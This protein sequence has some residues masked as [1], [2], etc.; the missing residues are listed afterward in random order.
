MFNVPSEEELQDTDTLHRAIYHKMINE[1]FILKNILYRLDR[2]YQGSDSILRTAIES[3]EG[4]QKGI[5]SKREI[6]K[7][8]DRKVAQDDYRTKIAVISKTAQEISDFVNNGFFRLKSDIQRALRHVSPDE[9]F[10]QQL[11]DLVARVEDSESA[12]NDLK[13]LHEGITIR[14]STFKITQI[15]ETWQTLPTFQH[16]TI[17]LDIQNGNQEFYG[18]EQKI[19]S[20]VN[21]LVENSVKHNPD[22]TDLRIDIVSY[23]ETNPLIKNQT[24]PADRRYLVINVRDNGKGVPPDKKEWV[25]LPLKSI[26]KQGGGL[27]LFIIYKTLRKMD[28]HIVETGADGA[29]FHIYIPYIKK[30]L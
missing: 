12:L 20:F 22:T 24:I 8:Q 18:D 3:I 17:H 21:E 15:F 19:R 27:G 4:I 10:Y 5:N 7:K 13:A 30:T 28:G 16:A 6:A 14:R 2:R 26:A 25:F 9:P 1:I 11:A 29:N 23:D